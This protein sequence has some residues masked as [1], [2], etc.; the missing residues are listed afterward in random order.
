M[1]E[2]YVET[3]RA[4]LMLSENEPKAKLQKKQVWS[5]TVFNS[6]LKLLSTHWT[7]LMKYTYLWLTDNYYNFFKSGRI[8]KL[9]GPQMVHEP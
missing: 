6:L 1:Y 3:Y 7:K 4:A 5:P 9:H 8:L 2:V